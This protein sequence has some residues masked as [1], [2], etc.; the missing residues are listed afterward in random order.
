MHTGSPE[1]M[2]KRPRNSLVLGPH[3][4]NDQIEL[5]N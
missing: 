2:K 1:M 4:I 3:S 5:R